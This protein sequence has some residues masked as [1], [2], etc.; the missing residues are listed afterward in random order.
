VKAVVLKQPELDALEAAEA[1]VREPRQELAR[2]AEETAKR[3]RGT[4][5]G[6]AGL[7]AFFSGSSLSPP[8]LPADVPTVAPPEHLCGLAA[9]GAVRMAAVRSRPDLATQTLARALDEGIALAAGKGG[10]EGDHGVSTQ[11]GK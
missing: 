6:C 7:A 11:P 5:A 8:G 2:V 3:A 4:P 10:W 9:V 1:W